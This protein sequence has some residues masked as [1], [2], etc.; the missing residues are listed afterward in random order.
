M[1]ALVLS[2]LRAIRVPHPG[3]VILVTTRRSK[4]RGALRR[5]RLRPKCWC[6][7]RVASS[8]YL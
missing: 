5:S 3:D 8:A 2:D 6:R 1:D 4:G 7:S